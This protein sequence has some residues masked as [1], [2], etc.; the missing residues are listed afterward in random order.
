[1]IERGIVDHEDLALRSHH[2]TGEFA[3]VAVPGEHVGHSHA[4]LDAGEAQNIGRM[5]QRIAFQIRGTASRVRDGG[6]VCI[7]RTRLERRNEAERA[8]E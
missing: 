6:I 4:R 5:I 3:V 2:V 7:R 1:M 8:N